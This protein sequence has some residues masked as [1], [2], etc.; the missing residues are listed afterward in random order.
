M[1][2]IQKMKGVGFGLAAIALT[3]VGLVIPVVLI[4]GIT[5]LSVHLA[6]WLRPAFSLTL[7]AC[8]FVFAPLA[9]FR[10]T[11]GFSAVALLIASFVFGGI[12][13]IASVLVTVQLWGTLALWIGIFMMGVGIVPV[14]IL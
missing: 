9:A 10:K 4:F 14:A 2:T 12:L 13:W 3:L 8:I 6:P 11:R 7:L 1:G 5:W